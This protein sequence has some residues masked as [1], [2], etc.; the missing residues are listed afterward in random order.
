M[1]V[2]AGLLAEGAG[3]PVTSGGAAGRP[4]AAGQ[5]RVLEVSDTEIREDQYIRPLAYKSSQIL[6]VRARAK[7]AKAVWTMLNPPVPQ[8]DTPVPVR[9]SPKFQA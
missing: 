9:P 6:G 8:G 2:A 7:H 3:Q 4:T 5:G 1:V